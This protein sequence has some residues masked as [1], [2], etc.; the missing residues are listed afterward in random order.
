MAACSHGLGETV[1]STS[2][3]LQTLHS[4][5]RWETLFNLQYASYVVHA[6]TTYAMLAIRCYIV[7]NR[8]VA[9]LFG[10]FTSVRAKLSL[11]LRAM[12]P[13]AIRFGMWPHAN[14]S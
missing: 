4:R 8:H 11:W 7:S 3:A 12:T 5:Q 14:K 1:K 13:A 2:L 10:A 9:S 6:T